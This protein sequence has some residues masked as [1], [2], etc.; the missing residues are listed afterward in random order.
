[1]SEVNATP[2]VPDSQSTTSQSSSKAIKV[3]TPDILLFDESSVPV[4]IMTEL[5]FEDIGGQ[6]IITISR[7]DIINGQEVSY[8]LIGNLSKIQKQYNSKNIFS[9]PETSEKY[10]KNFAI[11][12]DIH[13]PEKGTGP[14]DE[15]VYVESVGTDV[16]DAGDLIIDV[17]NM[18]INERVDVE[19][20]RRGQSLNDTI[21]TEES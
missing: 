2:D 5:I 7:N 16:S 19:I 6:E 1:M 13:V 20:L 17:I 21:Y 9:L 11:R 14:N 12:F 18:E 3:A 15:R 10:F 4:D 8:N